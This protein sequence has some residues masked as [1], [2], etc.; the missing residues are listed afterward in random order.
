MAAASAMKQKFIVTLLSVSMT[1]FLVGG[2]VGFWAF[3]KLRP[4]AI[5]SDDGPD[6]KESGSKGKPRGP[7]AQLVRVGAIQ[8]EKIVPVKTLVGDLVAVRSAAIATEVAGKVVALPVDEGSRVIGGETLLARIDD[9]W[10]K[11]EEDKIVTQIAEKNATLSFEKSDLERFE[12]L[13]RNNAISASE[14]E[15]KRSLIEGLEASLA[16][17]AVLRDEAATRSQRLEIFAPFDGSVVA[18]NAE[19]GEYLPI[20]SP[21]VQI[22]SSGRIDARIMVPE[23]SLMLLGEGDEIDCVVDSLGIELK[24]KVFSI[25]SQGSVGSRTFPVRVALDDQDG[26]LRPGMGVSAF[27][28]VMHEST[29]LMVP[30]DAV[31]TEPDESTIWILQPRDADDDSSPLVAEPVPVR[32]L[33]HTRDSYAIA[34]VREVDE[35]RVHS[36]VQVVT[37]GLERLVPGALVRVDADRAPL[38]SV[39]GTYRT[40]QQVVD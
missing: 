24:G 7:Q 6:G 25:N 4:A 18:K 37:E 15:Q 29:E 5:Q 39:P 27:V 17:L 12:Q 13:F 36:G 10:L 26:M 35:S 20:G 2:A 32:V 33:S 9:T 8:K 1:T 22:V 14:V 11:L 23:A 31:L 16:N 40:G 3:G 19:V 21:I 28:P 38:V 34:C 30:R